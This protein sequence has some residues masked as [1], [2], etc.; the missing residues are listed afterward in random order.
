MIPASAWFVAPVLTFFWLYKG[1]PFGRSF[2]MSFLLGLIIQAFKFGF[3]TGVLIV[4]L[5]GGAFLI[6]SDARQEGFRYSLV[7]AVLAFFFPIVMIPL[8]L[9]K[10]WMHKRSMEKAGRLISYEHGNSITFDK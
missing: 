2:M 7:Y 3:F 8:Y 10:K 6:Y 4:A 9:L 1:W 5:L